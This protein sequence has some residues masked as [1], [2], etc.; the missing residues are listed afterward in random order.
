MSDPP[1]RGQ[2]AR[3]P[4]AVPRSCCGGGSGS[5]PPAIPPSV[6]GSSSLGGD[7]S[8]ISPD[9]TLTR[10]TYST[11][12]PARSHHTLPCCRSCS[13]TGSAHSSQYESDLGTAQPQ[14]MEV[15]DTQEDEEVSRDPSVDQLLVE[16]LSGDLKVLTTSIAKAT[17]WVLRA[18]HHDPLSIDGGNAFAA[19]MM[20]FVNAIVATDFGRIRGVGDLVDISLASMLEAETSSREE[21]TIHPAP[22]FRPPP[23][24][25]ERSL[26][27]PTYPYRTPV[28]SSG[29]W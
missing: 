6:A 29:V 7:A 3:P 15:E 18:A 1:P 12:V 11:I 2:G 24:A 19:Q 20:A 26:Y 10:D 9:P 27:S 25:I 5:A 22:V 21:S 13:T 14:E 17:D 28:D 16:D 8:P 23:P 4:R